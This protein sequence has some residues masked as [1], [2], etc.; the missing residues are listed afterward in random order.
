MIKTII[1]AIFFSLAS[2][3]SHSSNEKYEP[4]ALFRCVSNEG[5]LVNVDFHRRIKGIGPQKFVGITK[6]PMGKTQITRMN[7][8][9]Y[10]EGRILFFTGS[11]LR[12][13]FDR[14]NMVQNKVEAFV[15]IPSIKIYTDAWTCKGP[16]FTEL[17]LP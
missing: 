1:P 7:L 13:R 5:E 17:P 11:D 6:T 10:H 9:H 4:E 8:T 15:Q 14:M 12:V 3:V 16:T 2:M